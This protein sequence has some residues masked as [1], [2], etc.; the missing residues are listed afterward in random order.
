MTTRQRPIP[1]YFTF[2]PL[3]RLAG[4]RLAVESSHAAVHGFATHHAALGAYSLMLWNYSAAAV[5]V[6]ASLEGMP[7]GMTVSPVVLDAATSRA[8]GNS[9]RN[10]SPVCNIF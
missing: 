3:S 4:E 7:G 1:T 8:E 2:K 6:E 9:R 5:E 10:T